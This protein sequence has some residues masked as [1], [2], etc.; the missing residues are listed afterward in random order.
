[1]FS[2]TPTLPRLKMCQRFMV[3][4]P[5]PEHNYTMRTW[6]KRQ[7]ETPSKSEGKVLEVWRSDRVESFPLTNVS[8]SISLHRRIYLLSDRNDFKDRLP[9]PPPT[10]Q[11][12]DFFRRQHNDVNR[13]NDVFSEQKVLRLPGFIRLC[14]YQSSRANTMSLFCEWW[15]DSSMIERCNQCCNQDAV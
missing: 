4:V 15:L 5:H 14:E 10:E 2:Q 8:P 3:K 1:V 12:W 11:G 6:P 9:P 13:A 7:T